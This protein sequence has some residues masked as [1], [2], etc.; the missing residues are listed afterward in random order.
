MLW[1]NV[2]WFREKHVTS[3]PREG[4]FLRGFLRPIVENAYKAAEAK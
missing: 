1:K 4:A 2:T 3:K